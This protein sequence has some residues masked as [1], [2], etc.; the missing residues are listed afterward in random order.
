M[1]ILC[2]QLNMKR[3]LF[4]PMQCFSILNAFEFVRQKDVRSKAEW[5]ALEISIQTVEF[6][7]KLKEI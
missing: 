4:I 5:F 3:H 6:F 2:I 1:I 7:P